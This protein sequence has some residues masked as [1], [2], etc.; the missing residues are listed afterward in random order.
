MYHVR[1]NECLDGWNG[2]NVL[3][4]KFTICQRQQARINNLPPGAFP[5][6]G[7]AK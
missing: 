1:H 6:P 3:S 5:Q 4:E 2:I 7:P